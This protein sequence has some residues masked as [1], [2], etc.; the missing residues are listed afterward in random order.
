MKRL[1]DS[2]FVESH[3][4]GFAFVRSGG[5]HVVIVE[6]FSPIVLLLALVLFCGL[7]Y[8]PCVSRRPFPRL[9][10]FLAEPFNP[11]C[12]DLGCISWKCL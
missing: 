8:G 5:R 10:W 6:E 11:P 2:Q 3:G 12:A 7:P 1:M 4:G 9:W